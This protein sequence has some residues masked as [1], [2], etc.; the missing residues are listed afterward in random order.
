MTTNS[1]SIFPRENF[2]LLSLQQCILLWEVE[3]NVFSSVNITVPEVHSM[4]DLL[5]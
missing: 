3:L 2:L 4:A 1:V 5:C